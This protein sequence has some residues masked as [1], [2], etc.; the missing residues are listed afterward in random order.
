MKTTKSIV[1]DLKVNG[2][3][4]ENSEPIKCFNCHHDKFIDIIHEYS[5]H[6]EV[7]IRNCTECEEIIGIK[8]QNVWEFAINLSKSS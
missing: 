7:V 4:N 5:I 8:N 3:I 6:E 1:K 2:Y